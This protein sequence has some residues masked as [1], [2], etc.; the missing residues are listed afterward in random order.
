MH[1]LSDRVF[2]ADTGPRRGRGV[3]ANAR[4]AAGERLDLSDESW[5]LLP[6]G[7]AKTLPRRALTLCCEYEHDPQFMLCPVDF[8]APPISHLVNHSCNPNLASTDNYETVLA[9]RD[10]SPREE[11]TFD[12]VTFNTGTDEFDCA[13]GAACCRGR[14]T[15][16]DWMR[17]DLQERYRS[18][19]QQNIQVKIDAMK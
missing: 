10:I 16:S 18:Y 1:L 6:L 5:R 19:F 9:L 15:G 7:D 14:F 3:F 8:D 13:C 12:Y 2:V 11:L 4:I 17:P